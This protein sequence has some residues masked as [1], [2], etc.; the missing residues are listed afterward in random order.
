[1]SHLMVKDKAPRKPQTRA[2]RAARHEICTYR[3]SEVNRNH[4]KASAGLILPVEE[5]EPIMCEMFFGVL[6]WPL[7]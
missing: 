3:N 7:N 1:M 6:T 4:A 2:G 5:R